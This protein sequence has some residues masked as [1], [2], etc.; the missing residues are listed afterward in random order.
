MKSDEDEVI[1]DTYNSDIRFSSV[2][3]FLSESLFVPVGYIV[4]VKTLCLDLPF[5]V[6][7]ENYYISYFIYY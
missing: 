7:F 5:K 6:L 4:V 2:E 1:A 3:L